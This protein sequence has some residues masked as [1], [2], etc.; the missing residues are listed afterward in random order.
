MG[1]DYLGYKSDLTRVF[2]LGKI[3]TLAFKIYNI[4]KEAQRLAIK[5]IRPG[6]SCTEIDAVA[7]NYIASKGYAKN[8]THSLGHGI[9]L[10]VHESPYITCG[11]NEILKEGMVFTV[12]PAIYLPGKFG[13]RIE[14]MVLVVK[15]GCEVLSGSIDK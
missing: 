13:V 11:N 9:G 4:I 10:N 8:F 1:V 6:K 3:N 2:F 14:D 15:N 7:R 12:E 5:E